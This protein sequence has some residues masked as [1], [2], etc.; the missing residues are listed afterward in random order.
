M[1]PSLLKKSVLFSLVIL[2]SV[3]NANAQVSQTVSI[4]PGYTNRTFYQM[5]S[6]TVSTLSLLKTPA[7]E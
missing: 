5:N 2:A 1:K 7:T 4:S 3:L 6:G